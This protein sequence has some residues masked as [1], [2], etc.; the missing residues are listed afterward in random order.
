MESVIAI[1]ISALMVVESDGN[2][3]AIGDHG[4][5]VGVLQI[6][7][8]CVQDVNRQTGNAYTLQDRKSILKSRE[9]CAAY[10]A[11]YGK[12]YE[13]KTG[14]TATAEVYS[15]IWNGGPS[16]YAKSATAHY[17]EKTRRELAKRESGTQSAA[18]AKTTRPEMP[19]RKKT[20]TRRIGRI[21]PR[22]P[23]R[24]A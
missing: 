7:P 16:G 17:W 19:R 9:I 22:E 5:A 11:H 24:A 1:L 8:E 13:R 14:K 21:Y 23:R 3:N 2:A 10:L 6:H 15:R 4:K 20:A 12:R 18:T